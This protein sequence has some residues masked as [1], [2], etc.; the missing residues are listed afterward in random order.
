M[1]SSLAN[2]V[3]ASRST[4]NGSKLNTGSNIP[5]NMYTT[6]NTLKVGHKH[7]CRCNYGQ[8][9][10]RSNIIQ[11]QLVPNDTF[12]NALIK[13][14][15]A[16]LGGFQKQL[17][18]RLQLRLSQTGFFFGPASVVKLVMKPFSASTSVVKPQNHGFTSFMD[19]FHLSGSKARTEKSFCQTFFKTAPTP[20]EKP[21]HQMSQSRSCFQRSRSPAKQALRIEAD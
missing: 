15:R 3:L 16:C 20:P 10:I 1:A 14:V 8:A 11:Q 13:Y 5:F 9:I 2:N 6:Q 7:C 12:T 19:G 18:L 17:Q 21:L 4:F